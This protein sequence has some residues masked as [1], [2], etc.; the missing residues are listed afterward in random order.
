MATG[1]VSA[2]RIHV[3]Q[4]CGYPVPRQ[5]Y[6]DVEI[7]LLNDLGVSACRISTEVGGSGGS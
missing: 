5:L 2:H 6:G 4:T 3:A 7:G 1:S